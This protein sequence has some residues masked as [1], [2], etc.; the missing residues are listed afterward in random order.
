MDEIKYIPSIVTIIQESEQLAEII[1]EDKMLSEAKKKA[2]KE[3]KV[4]RFTTAFKNLANKF[5][6]HL[7]GIGK[8]QTIGIGKIVELNN[9]NRMPVMIKHCVVA[10]QPKLGGTLEQSFIGAHNVCYATFDTYGLASARTGLPTA[11]GKL[12]ERYHM[13]KDDPKRNG[14]SRSQK[15]SKY[16]S[17]YKKVF[18]EAQFPAEIWKA[19][20]PEKK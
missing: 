14:L 2:V 19:I 17:M 5:K 9:S 18:K 20:Y 1:T 3:I 10:V 12:R 11:R 8:S 16:R 4:D 6:K 15:E 7:E 13:S